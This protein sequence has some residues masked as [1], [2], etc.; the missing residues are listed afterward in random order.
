MWT[1]TALDENHSSP[2]GPDFHLAM[3]FISTWHPLRNGFGSSTL[4]LIMF[5]ADGN[6]WF[7][8]VALDIL[9]ITT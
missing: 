8:E 4:Y 1:A 9:S 7:L 5:E 6:I 2:G 3:L